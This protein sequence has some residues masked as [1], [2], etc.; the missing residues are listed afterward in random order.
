MKDILVLKRANSTGYALRKSFLFSEKDI[1]PLGFKLQSIEQMHSF[2]TMENKAGQA[3]YGSTDLKRKIEV[4]ILFRTKSPEI[5][6]LMR[7]ELFGLFNNKEP[8][9]I[10]ET[11][12][13]GVPIT[14]KVYQVKLTEI[15]EIERI[16][17]SGKL[18]L[19]FQ[20]T[21]LPYGQ[22]I[23]TTQDIQ[24]NEIV[25]D[26][27]WAFGMGLETVD[28]N[29]L[30]YT[31]S[32]TSSAQF[33]IF[34]AGNVEVHPFETYLK[35]VI[36]NVKGSTEMFQL[37]NSTNGSKARINVPVKTTD[38]WTYNGPNITR[39]S[40]AAA[41]DTRKDFIYLSPGWNKF[42]LYYCDSA[43]VSFDFGFLY[44]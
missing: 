10:A 30:I 42:Q 15:L 25:I 40:L 29:E 27:N 41:K 43:E 35:L 5:F 34:N 7:D 8:V 4:P 32:A 3:D 6:S 1:I 13:K 19:V 14:G 28:D 16:G 17:N 2:V 23:M 26:R 18:S 33:G 39:N 24:T 31:H 37:T 12:S 21:D 20:T 9:F 38:V 36:K 44:R 11:D 22:S